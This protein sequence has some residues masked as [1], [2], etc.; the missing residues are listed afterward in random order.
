MS[1]HRVARA[2]SRPRI[3]PLRVQVPVAATLLILEMFLDRWL[4]IVYADGLVQLWDTMSD[5]V[6]AHAYSN[7]SL[8]YKVCAELVDK[9]DNVPQTT[10]ASCAAE[11]SDDEQ[12][13]I[14]LLNGT[15][16]FVSFLL[17]SGVLLKS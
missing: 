2:W 5:S 3:A 11:V 17:F 16:Q 12:K 6:P 10:W 4:L 1:T 9:A 15:S 14:L 13:L 7:L 8:R